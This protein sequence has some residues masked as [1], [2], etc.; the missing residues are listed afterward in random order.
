MDVNTSA[1]SHKWLIAAL[2]LCLL[3]CALALRLWGIGFGLPYLYHFDE[4]FY[5]NT[6]LKTG[7]GVLHYPPNTVPGLSNLLLLEYGVYYV[8]GKVSGVFAGGAEFEAAFRSDPTVF[9]L[10]GR[11]TTALISTVGVFVAYVL[12]SRT[13]SRLTG[14][15]AA[16][17]LAVAFLDVRN[18]HY[19]IPDVILSFLAL[20]SVTFACIGVQKGRASFVYWAALTGGWTLA[21]KWTGLAVVIPLGLA[22]FFVSRAGEQPS[23]KRLAK[24]A[25]L[26][27]IVFLVGFALAA[28]QVLMAPQLYAGEISNQQDA[29][30]TGGF[31]LWQVDTVPG[32]IF[33]LKMLYYGLGLPMLVFAFVGLGLRLV[34]AIRHKDAFSAVLISFPVVY[35]AVMGATTHYFA[36]YAL[37]LVPFAA[38]FAAQGIVDISARVP[39]QSRRLGLGLAV[40][41]V[42]A[43]LAQPLI[44]S[45]RHNVLLTRTDTRTLAKEWIEQN[46]PAGAKIAVEWRTHGPP[47]AT[48]ERLVPYAT[49]EYAAEVFELAGLSEHPIEWYRDQGFEYLIS[50]SFIADNPLVDSDK[51]R[52]RQ[53]F[54]QELPQKLQL[55]QTF[56]PTPNGTDPSFIF[57]E[58]YG[59]FV[60]LWERERPGPV[61]KI[62]KQEQ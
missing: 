7:T 13:A 14:L 18:A 10:L 45:V 8:W 56:S 1:K 50:T 35:F 9:Y 29:G 6:A 42:V 52:I 30:S 21:M 11:I 32:W 23:K 43:G 41:L 58:I 62:Y 48:A 51:D 28:P 33:Y 3:A 55:L 47:L 22:V 44:A 16:A 39:Q 37:P 59:P 38:V 4:H 60:S 49:R 36:R 26:A 54:Y 27:A 31:Q 5:V 40:L 20:L 12:A 17:F 19:L 53:A 57:D 46:I 2:V 34:R 25:L 24:T 61:L 15:I